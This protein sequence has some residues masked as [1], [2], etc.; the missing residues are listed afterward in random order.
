[1]IDR[2]L[3][4]VIY[5]LSA[6]ISVIFIR[7]KLNSTY[8]AK[9][10]VL[11]GLA[12]VLPTIGF[13]IVSTY[14]A[15]PTVLFAAVILGSLFPIF[16]ILIYLNN[17]ANNK[18]VAPW[19]AFCLV[20]PTIIVLF[21]FLFCLLFLSGK[22]TASE[23]AMLSEQVKLN[24]ARIAPYIPIQET[25]HFESLKHGIEKVI[26]AKSIAAPPDTGIVREIVFMLLSALLGV[27]S[28]LTAN[29]IQKKIGVRRNHEDSTYV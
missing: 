21:L 19:I 29:Y 16:N 13:Y 12:V 2:E 5:P 6:I 24:F 9:G 14:I 28:S 26:A 11:I 27:V 10:L 25:A 7:S 3:I 4:I 18:R 8:F 15:E 1:V 17:G 23:V 22:V 20:F